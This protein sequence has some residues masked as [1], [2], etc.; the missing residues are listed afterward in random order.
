MNP[1]LTCAIKASIAA[2]ARIMEIYESENFGIEFKEDK[3][4]LT[5]ADT[6]SNKIIIDYLES[7]G[8][9]ILSEEGSFIPYEIR[10]S[11]DSLWIVDPIDGTKEFIKR[12]GD[13][14]VNIALIENGVPQLG[15]VYV[16]ALKELYFASPE[17]GAMKSKMVENFGSMHELIA[18]SEKLPILHQRNIYTV[19]ASQSHLNKET[20]D[21]IEE[22]K[23]EHG[24]IELIQRGSSLKL[25]LVAE[26]F[27]DCYPRFGP[28]ME[29]DTAAGHAICKYSGATLTDLTTKVEMIYNKEELRNNW[30]VAQRP[31]SPQSI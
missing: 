29:W 26:G 25:C 19:L 31:Q 30:F 6:A 5:L 28:I 15:V 14:T 23:N 17:T 12:N 10:K 11:Y 3:S 24:E 20:V 22:L 4:P 1:L 9:P 2:G 8:I 13:F 21:F 27:A 16:P 7:T 18:R